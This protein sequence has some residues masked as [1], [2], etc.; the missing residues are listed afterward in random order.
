MNVAFFP[1]SART[2]DQARALSQCNS[3]LIAKMVYLSYPGSQL[4]GRDASFAKNEE[5]LNMPVLPF[6]E[7]TVND[8]DTL[9]LLDDDKMV[10]FFDLEQVVLWASCS[11]VRILN[12]CQHWGP[13]NLVRKKI[14]SCCDVDLSS[15]DFESSF[16]DYERNEVINNRTKIHTVPVIAVGG[17]VEEA[18][19]FAV[20]IKLVLSL[21]RHGVRVSA[22][23]KAPIC[24]FIGMHNIPESFLS[25]NLS[26]EDKIGIMNQYI[27]IIIKREFPKIFIIQM[28]GSIIRLNRIM[29][30][31]YG[32]LAYMLSQSTLLSG[33]VCCMPNGFLND[34]SKREL[35]LI[36]RRHFG[37]RIIGFHSSNFSL[38]YQSINGSRTFGGY[39]SKNQ[40]VQQDNL[41]LDKNMENLTEIIYN[42][43]ACNS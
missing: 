35:D 19:T 18:D 13:D 20:F 37:C 6:S 7:E 24:D 1:I 26:E 10:D 22:M 21:R 32:I 2:I 31:G 8:C 38:N 40:F 30:N 39:Y 4:I 34:G 9:V 41:L 33:L 11:N 23:G 43:L 12:A 27:D 3:N 28:P 16:N 29:P 25:G 36:S 15:F 14:E 17:T 5:F 42:K